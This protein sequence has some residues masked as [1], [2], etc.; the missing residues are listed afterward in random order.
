VVRP[1]G[2]NAEAIRVFHSLGFDV[3]TRVELTY[4]LGA[5]DRWREGEEIAGRTFRV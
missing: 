4:D 1:T 2:R 5:G 3:V